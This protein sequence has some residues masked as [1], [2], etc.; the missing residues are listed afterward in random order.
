MQ[1]L[2]KRSEIK[3]PE[4]ISQSFR[5]GQH[6]PI[7]ENKTSKSFQSAYRMKKN[8]GKLTLTIR[9]VPAIVCYD[10]R[11]KFPQLA[12]CASSGYYNVRQRRLPFRTKRGWLQAVTSGKCKNV[13]PYC[14]RH[15]ISSWIPN[16][17]SLAIC[18]VK[19]IRRL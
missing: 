12:S 6:K 18:T 5:L 13:T 9:L 10:S 11:L 19:T 14:V 1:L 8:F 2:M 3:W 7:T 16:I 15:E 4:A 17:C